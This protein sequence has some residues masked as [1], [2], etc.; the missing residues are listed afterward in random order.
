[1]THFQISQW[2]AWAPG[3]E[4]EDQWR[5]WA[6]NTRSMAAQGEPEVPFLPPMQRRRCDQLSRM[7]LHV[8]HACCEESLLAEVASV[9]ASRHGPINTTAILLSDLARQASISPAR[10]SHSVHNAPAGLFSIWAANSRPSISLAAGSE[11]FAHGFLEALCMLH[12][13]LGEPVLYVMGEESIP[14]PLVASS[15][16]REQPHAIALLFSTDASGGGLEFKLEEGGTRQAS[17]GLGDSLEFM[18]W[19][20]SDEPTLCIAHEDRTWTWTRAAK[21]RD[22]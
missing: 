15:D 8:V 2:S 9:F 10:F 21:E 5:E 22:P 13:R 3:V 16:H 14:D 20:L 19:W 6:C 11:T 17:Q 18:R 4:S 1:M 7:V 12:R